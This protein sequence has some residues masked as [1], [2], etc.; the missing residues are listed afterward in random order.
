MNN[1]YIES[2]LESLFSLYPFFLKDFIKYKD[3]SIINSFLEKDVKQF[4]HELSQYDK[5]AY[6]IFGNNEQQDAHEAL[7]KIIDIFDILTEKKFMP[8]YFGGKIENIV[9]CKTCNYYNITYSPFI[10]LYVSSFENILKQKTEILNDA[11][12]EECKSPSLY[13]IEDIT[14]YPKILICVTH[15]KN[16]KIPIK[17]KNYYFISCI[18]HYGSTYGGHYDLITCR[19]FKWFKIDGE[20]YQQINFPQNFTNARVIF[21]IRS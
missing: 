9:Q 5:E 21:F 12:C 8:K 7:L 13:R 3:N 11:L 19:D 2:V 16:I 20:N 6:N 17:F 4:K 18:N 1:C 14:K 10:D 15:V